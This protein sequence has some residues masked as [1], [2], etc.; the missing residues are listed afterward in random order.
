MN[1]E[2]LKARSLLPPA[3]QA[4]KGL[5]ENTGHRNMQLYFHESGRNKV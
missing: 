2:Y 1:D 4:N 3:L 5:N